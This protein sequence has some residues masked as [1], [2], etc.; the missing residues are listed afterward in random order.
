M[1]K[2]AVKACRQIGYNII[3]RTRVGRACNQVDNAIGSIDDRWAHWTMGPVAKRTGATFD[4]LIPTSTSQYPGTSLGDP[5][6]NFHASGA[7]HMNIQYTHEGILQTARAMHQIGMDPP[8]TSDG[9]GGGGGGGGY[10]C[11]PNDPKLVCA[12]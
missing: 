11:D 3:I 10:S 12:Q 5:A 4:G 8:P 9:G 1:V 6:V 2:S 7:N